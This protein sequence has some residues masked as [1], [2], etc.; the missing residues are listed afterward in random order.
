MVL[1][2]LPA[3][4]ILRNAPRTVKVRAGAVAHLFLFAG[5]APAIFVDAHAVQWELDRICGGIETWVEIPF[6]IPLRY[7]TNRIAPKQ[8]KPVIIGESVHI[9]GRGG[10]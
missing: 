7:R 8:M 5:C 10:I 6:E 3:S 1:D 2:A 4:D 9:G